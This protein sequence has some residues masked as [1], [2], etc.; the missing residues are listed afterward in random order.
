MYEEWV[1]SYTRL[2]FLVK[3]HQTPRMTCYPSN[4]K[5]TLYGR[6]KAFCLEK[7]LAIYGDV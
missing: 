3:N 6:I 7:H 2:E 4:H 5:G 1:Y